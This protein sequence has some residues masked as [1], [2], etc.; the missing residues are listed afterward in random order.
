MYRYINMYVCTLTTFLAPN[1]Y[2]FYL[3]LGV[4]C[5]WS[6]DYVHPCICIQSYFCISVHICR[7]M[8]RYIYTLITLNSYFSLYIGVK[9]DWSADYVHPCICIQSYFCISVHICRYMY[10]YIYTLITLNSYFSLYIGV[11]CDW[12]ADYVH[13][14]G[15]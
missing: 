10:R 5:D 2:S 3:Y 7:Y 1:P 6:A 4:K 15:H 8:Y 14:N 13:S 11:K 9:C 12:S